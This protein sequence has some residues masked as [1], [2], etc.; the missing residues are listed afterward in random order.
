MRRLSITDR[1]R[2]NV[3]ALM[4]QPNRPV[5]RQAALMKATGLSRGQ[6][7]S[8]LNGRY[9]IGLK[10]LDG[11]A[12]A[13]GV[14]VAELVRDTE[15][16]LM[17]LTHEQ[18]RLVTYVRAWHPEVLGALMLVLDYFHAQPEFDELTANML[19]MWRQMKTS[20]R[21]L[22]YANALRRREESIPPEVIAAAQILGEVEE[23]P[24]KGGRRRRTTGGA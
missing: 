8:F 19:L 4:K 15:R 16:P 20:E 17:E 9:G 5:V 24:P 18:A 22:T 23:P 11:L 6:V 10:H 14:S 7:S 1:I 2:A 12:Y 13:L 21:A 3:L